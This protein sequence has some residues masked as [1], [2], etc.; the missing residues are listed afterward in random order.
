MKTRPVKAISARISGIVQGVGFRYATVF[1]ARRLQVRGFVRNMP[2]GTVEAVGEGA[3]R[4]V[5]ALVAWLHRGPPGAL[6]RDVTIKEI[7]YSGEFN[8]FS[9]DY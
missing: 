6:V 8:R 7:P 2:D 3:E 4:D 5:D 1:E 9:V